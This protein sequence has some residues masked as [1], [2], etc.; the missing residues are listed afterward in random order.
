MSDGGGTTQ[1]VHE[2]MGEYGARLDALE[3]N[4]LRADQVA[5]EMASTLSRI[6]AQTRTPATVQANNSGLEAAA[7]ALMRVADV[8][9]DKPADLPAQ[10]AAAL[11]VAAPQLQKQTGGMNW[12]SAIGLVAIGLGVGAVLM[13]LKG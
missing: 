6:E 9:K 11:A 10:I 4:Q 13:F 12:L 7:L 3:R 2:R 1:V 8:M 5:R